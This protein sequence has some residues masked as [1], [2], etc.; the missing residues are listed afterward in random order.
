MSFGY[1][2]RSCRYNLATTQEGAKKLG[3]PGFESEEGFRKFEI[4]FSG[5]DVVVDAVAFFCSSCSR[6]L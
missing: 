3:P 5:S 4:F 2:L 1:S 6:D